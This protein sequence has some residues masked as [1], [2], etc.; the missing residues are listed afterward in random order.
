MPIRLT[1]KGQ[2]K[3]LCDNKCCAEF[4]TMRKD[5]ITEY[6]TLLPD[7]VPTNA[8]CAWCSSLVVPCQKDPELVPLQLAISRLDTEVRNCCHALEAERVRMA[9][10][11][12]KIAKGQELKTQADS[13]RKAWLL[14]RNLMLKGS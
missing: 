10:Q 3:Y 13:I 1:I 6:T 9:G 2:T 7:N 4:N 12:G 11:Q 14:I 5:T 8:F